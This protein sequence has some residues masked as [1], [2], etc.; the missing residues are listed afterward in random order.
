MFILSESAEKMV[1]S[2]QKI[3]N[4]GEIRPDDY[5]ALL[6]EADKDGRIDLRE[7]AILKA[8]AELIANKLVCRVANCTECP[9]PEKT[10][11]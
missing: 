2:L 5:E 9:M 11:S 8:L 7:Q 3:I 10:C 4:R 6:A 1:E